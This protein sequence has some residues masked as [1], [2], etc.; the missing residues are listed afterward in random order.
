MP[1]HPGT[2]AAVRS[3]NIAEMI[4]AGHPR[5]QAIAAAYANAERHPH[6]AGGT[7]GFAHI[8]PPHLMG[9]PHVPRA[10]AH[11]GAPSAPMHIGMP[12]AGFA[13]GGMGMSPSEAEP[14]WTRSE[15]RG[16]ESV[17]PG[18]LV[19]SPTGGRADH[20]PVSVASSAYV[21]PAD[22]ISGLGEGSTLAGAQVVDRML[23]TLPFG[24]QPTRLRGRGEPMPHPS[25]AVRLPPPP[26]G[27]YAAGGLAG[28]AAGRVPHGAGEVVPCRLSGGEYVVNPDKVLAIGRG[29][30]DLGHDILD[31]FIK[32]VRERTIKEMKAL[33]GPKKD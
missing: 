2:S 21:L 12:R 5:D 33:P 24:I 1:L 29:D 4:R 18:G 17:H 14:W 28:F 9:G 15:A 20:V 31:A 8:L 7:A 23:S 13:F 27:Q 6:A 30:M 19:A 3:A 25:G 10:P 16:E 22:V 26:S 11:M 32:K